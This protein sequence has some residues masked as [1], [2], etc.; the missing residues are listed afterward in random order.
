M[1]CDTI[2]SFKL[3]LTR[4]YKTYGN[5]RGVCYMAVES[6]IVV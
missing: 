6:Y 5:F 2:L 1:H 4:S 3:S